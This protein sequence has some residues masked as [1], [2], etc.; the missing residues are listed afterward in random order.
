M[1]I[2]LLG[3]R[4]SG[5]TTV[6]RK[7][8]M[9][10]W[11]DFVDTDA[12]VCKRFGNA[13]IAEIWQAHGEAAFREAECAVVADLLGRS[14]QV[15]ALGGGSVMQPAARQAIESAADTVRI[16]LKCD[17]DVLARR[18][19][20]DTATRAS[21][22]SLTVAGDTV[23]EIQQVLAERDPVYEAVADHILDVTRMTPAD[24]IR[25]MIHRCL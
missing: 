12:E 14:E 18:L 9:E 23:T 11:K 22:P 10:L 19:E 20:A 3:Y 13:T 8:A 15:I 24:V 5:K 16:Y 17:A 6:G 7:L 25:H 4:G 1:N 21:R 2:V